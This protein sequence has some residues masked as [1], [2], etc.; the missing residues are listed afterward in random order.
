M[1]RAFGIGQLEIGGDVERGGR[2]RRRGERVGQHE[3]VRHE[4]A[5]DEQRHGEAEPGETPEPPARAL[6]DR[7]NHPEDRQRDP[8][9]HERQ[10]D[11]GDVAQ[12]RGT[13]EQREVA[14]HAAERERGPNPGGEIEAPWHAQIITCSQVAGVP[15]QVRIRAR[16]SAAVSQQRGGVLVSRDDPGGRKRLPLLGVLASV[17]VAGCISR[18][19]DPRAI[20]GRLSGEPWAPFDGQ[21]VPP[22]FEDESRLAAALESAL[23]EARS[24]PSARSLRE[25]GIAYLRFA[26]VEQAV[27]T[28][29]AAVEA[30]RDSP[31]IL[32]DLSA[33]LMA[34]AA[35]P[36]ARS[37]DWVDAVEA[38]D[39]A[40]ELQPDLLEAGYNAALGLE[41]LHLALP[42]KEAWSRYLELEHEPDWASD[43]RSRARDLLP[44]LEPVEAASILDRWELQPT[45]L[46]AYRDVAGEVAYGLL[47]L[48]AEAYD[49]GRSHVGAALAAAE[50]AADLAYTVGRDALPLESVRTVRSS[51]KS[52]TMHEELVRGHALYAEAMRHYDAR[53]IARASARFEAAGA[54]LERAG[55]PFRVWA[56]LYM[57]A[58]D[59]Y[60]GEFERAE[61]RLQAIERAGEAS[62]SLTGHAQWMLGLCSMVRAEFGPA[63]SHYD[64]ALRCFELAGE[65]GNAAHVEFLLAEGFALLGDEQGAWRRRQQGLSNLRFVRRPRR[66]EAI[67]IGT[68]IAALER[69]TP[70]FA[71]HAQAEVLQSVLGR[72]DP[73]GECEARTWRA[74]VLASLHHEQEALL[75]LAGAERAL[76]RV[77]DPALHRRL[78]AELDAARGQTAIPGDPRRAVAAIGAAIESFDS[79]GREARLA[80]LLLDRGRARHALGDDL[81]AEADWLA[82]IARY[83]RARE[84]LEQ[85]AQ[86]TTFF[87]LARQAFD[88]LVELQIAGKAQ[89]E[90]GLSLSERARARALLDAPGRVKE[91][92]SAPIAAQPLEARQIAERLPVDTALVSYW[93]GRERV[94][95][96][97]LEAGHIRYFDL[98]IEPEELERTVARFRHALSLA[99][100]DPVVTELAHELFELLVAPAGLAASPARKLVF[101]PDRFLHGLPFAALRDPRDERYLVEHGVVTIAPSATM[102]VMQGGLEPHALPRRP[103]SALVVG[104]PRFDPSRHPGL[105]NLPLAVEEARHVAESYPQATLLLGSDATRQ[106]LLQEIP[107]HAVF[108]FAGHAS[109]DEV[110]PGR[111]RLV[112]APGE[113][114][115]SVDLTADDVVGLRLPATEL[116]VLAACGT[117][118]GRVSAGEGSLS[119]ARAFLVAGART[120]IA[121]LWPIDDQVGLEISAKLHHTIVSGATPE[122][123]LRRTQLECLASERAELRAPSAWAAFQLVGTRGGPAPVDA[124]ARSSPTGRFSE[125]TYQPGRGVRATE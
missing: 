44:V 53:D 20:E 31:A 33:A 117:A 63:I 109:N 125:H 39:Q 12:D 17:V 73:V 55:S 93:V 86:R 84:S 66:R 107:G 79:E 4:K 106:R 5:A 94:S 87:D 13:G 105:A 50:A 101:V 80:E 76:D 72:G 41:R 119:I 114:G 112:L 60:E 77:A 22:R 122:E 61:R 100:R 7:T 11:P 64:R 99:A 92:R 1:H 69:G 59:Y 35:R 19:P 75:E 42:A 32:S 97:V 78:A 29:R 9:E 111:S 110:Q 27:V 103:S 74:R 71:L 83:E 124:A 36:E 98:G 43:A 91:I 123:A 47:G 2:G 67:L 70:R 49:Q 90:R 10:V 52:G 18:N 6:P 116:V 102:F 85:D 89:A 56:V 21:P 68:A 45:T 95:A 57:A 3:H 113:D 118:E 121:T 65:T 58:C 82:A 38:A 16:L 26:N 37:T 120:V 14:D 30:D 34:R 15:H 108:H 88:E 8:A 115:T 25:L 24:D 54:S 48:W 62:P 28:L 40:L 51:E 81:A 104:N 46:L 23:I 96:W